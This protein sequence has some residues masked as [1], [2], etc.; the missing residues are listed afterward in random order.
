MRKLQTI[1][2]ILIVFV[3]MATSCTPK[4]TSTTVAPT[5]V[6][7]TKVVPPTNTPIAIVVKQAT[8]TPVPTLAPQMV[9][10]QAPMLD[11][12]VAAGTLPKV[13]ER[14]PKDVS[15]IKPRESIGTYG[16][17]LNT[18][19]WWPE[20]G[21]VQ[22]YFAVEAPI[23][24]KEDLTG[25]EPALV[26][27]YEWSA[28]GKTFTFHMREGLKWSDGV[29]YTS[30]DWKF[31]WEDMANNSDY[32]GQGSGVAA[33][34]RNADGTPITLTF[35]DDYT[36]VWTSKDRPLFIDP[37]FLAQGFWEFA[38]NKMMPA[39]YLKQFH[40]K[41]DTTKTYA[42]L[43]SHA[44]YWLNPDFP[45]LFA[46]C[47]S[48]V[49]EDGSY[50]VL[51]RNPYYWR[52]DTEGNQLPYIDKIHVD[53]ISDEQVRILN[54]SQGKYDTDFRIGGGPNEIP[55]ID[56]QAAKVGIKRLQ[57]W[58]NGAGA[59]PGYMVNQYYVE[60]G[61]NYTDDTPENAKEIRDL[62]RD[63][64]FRKALSWGVDRNRVIAVA[65]N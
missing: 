7:P 48:E 61:K 49:A 40:P 55:L 1:L 32:K 46:W 2:V 9:Y 16:G 51:S 41:Y 53:I 26:K 38:N 35:P 43:D 60:G 33:Y 27:S 30:A 22:L 21:N 3:I 25:Y 23:M 12:L 24:W 20:Y 56:E 37:F 58:M 34:M 52:V 44:K 62:L 18:A 28:D 11:A 45:C 19:S 59:W 13:E 54:I 36:I 15:V 64:K 50:A 65:W 39:H 29:P 42:D 5:A 63:S 14:L 31:Y 6:P 47:P 17:T 10:K 57:G 4:A 8:D